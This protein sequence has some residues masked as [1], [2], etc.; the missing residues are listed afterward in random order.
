MLA[1]EGRAFGSSEEVIMALE[2]GEVE[3]LTPIR[4]RYTGEVID[5]T[6]AYDDQDVSHT[7]PLYLNKQFLHTTVGRV[8]F[9]D[10]LPSDMPFINGLLKKKGI[11]ALVQY[12]YLRFG[13]EKT[14]LMLDH[15]KELGFLYAT[16]SGVS[17]G[18]S[19]MVIRSVK[20]KLVDA[21]RSTRWSKSS[22]NI[23]MAPLPTASAITKSSPFGATLPR[24]LRTKCSR[25]LEEQDKQGVINPVYVM[26][27]SGARGSKQQIRQLSGMRVV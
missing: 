2:A 13:L 6:N 19:D 3:L 16:K 12:A 4:M 21:A 17:I 15:L 20:F 14:V 1:G 25:A 22:S 27:D 8:I 10:H 26:A 9:N 18:I 7:E 23:L 5:L 11:Q 24:R